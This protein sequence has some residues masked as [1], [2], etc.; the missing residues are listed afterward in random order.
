MAEVKTRL[1]IEDNASKKLEKI[2]KALNSLNKQF[3]TLPKKTDSFAKAVLKSANQAKRLDKALLSMHKSSTLTAA[4]LNATNTSLNRMNQSMR[5][6][7]SS[8]SLLIGKL[9]MLA[10]TY[11]G[12]MGAK[13]MVTASDDLTSAENKFKTIGMNEG[14]TATQ[15]KALSQSSMD[16]IFAAS[17]NA[18]TDYIAMAGNVA[19]SVTLSGAAFGKN[20]EEQIANATRF[21]NIMAKTYALGG[22]SAAEQSS[23]MYQLVQA[24][25]AGKL[26]GDELRSVTEGAPLAGKAIEKFANKIYGT[27]LALKDLGSQGM[28]TSEIVVGAILEMGGTVDD[29][30]AQMDK[31]FAQLWISFKNDA[32]KAFEPFLRQLREISNSDD[33]AFLVDKATNALYAFA[34][35]ATQALGHVENALGWIRE[36]WNTFETVLAIGVTLL[37][38][39]IGTELAGTFITFKNIAIDSISNVTNWFNGLSATG[40]AVTRSLGAIGAIALICYI[41]FSMMADASESL[42]TQLGILFMMVAAI[43]GVLMIFG[44]IGFSVPLLIIAGLLL[45]VGAFMA[46]TDVIVGGAA[47][48]VAFV[49]NLFIGLINAIIEFAWAYFVAPWMKIYEFFYNLFNDGFNGLGG[50]FANL[51][52]NIISGFLDLA[53]IVTPIID[54][55]FGTDWT[56]KLDTLSESVRSWGKN[57]NAL[58]V[59]TSTPEMLTIDKRFDLTDAYDSG[60]ALGTK[61][62]SGMDD[63]FGKGTDFG[64]LFD[65][66]SKTLVDDPSQYTYDTNMTQ[67][68]LANIDDNTATTANAVEL[69]EEDLKYLR[70]M[71]EQEAINKFTTAEIRVDMTNHNSVSRDTDLDGVV[72]HL[73]SVLREELMALADGVHA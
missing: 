16:N 45:L 33:F 55:I 71:A 66:P 28:L 7:T 63:F 8:S 29:Q 32:K 73:T 62:K 36:N 18:Y 13:A 3:A 30:F 23:S 40:Q 61:W 9:R 60:A 57:E 51:I 67:D 39:K 56:D 20:S 64:G 24:L 70:L 44:I 47:W 58:T 53:K 5:K 54:A 35:V 10:S 43:I 2:E 6:S 17:Q 42:A 4:G 26:Q 37:G 69:S 68:Y 12:V 15:S 22:A 49:L 65:D 11:L 19:K 41:G 72:T 27:D 48:L 50:I 21:Q 1:T 14:M 46:F 52:G 34:D 59:D 31:T 38:A 25:G